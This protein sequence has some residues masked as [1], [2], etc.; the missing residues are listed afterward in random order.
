MD[1]NFI[2]MI[3]MRRSRYEL[4]N[5]SPLSEEQINE[6]V[7]QVVQHVPSAFHSESARA[8]ILFQEAH[9]Q[10]WDITTQTLKAIV[11]A[12]KF[13]GTQ[14]KMNAFDQAYGTILFFEDQAVVSGLQ[15]DFPLYK[16]VFPV[17]SNQSAGMV[18]FAVWTALA[19]AGLG[20]S[21]QHYNPLIDEAVKK[22]FVLPAEWKLMAQMPFGK[23]TAPDEDKTFQDIKT[24]V[25]VKK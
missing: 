13:A 17:W 15:K 18:Q 7:E 5:T 20:A 1:K 10:L 25:F 11:P 4:T 8:V 12:N 19:E 14:K 23:A 22:R 2:D 24:R 21:L 6:L 16:E 9:H 3:K